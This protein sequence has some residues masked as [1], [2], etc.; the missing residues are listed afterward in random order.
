MSVCT[1]HVRTAV[2]RRERHLPEGITAEDVLGGSVLTLV[3]R[4]LPCTVRSAELVG[5]G[6]PLPQR[7][8]RNEWPSRQTLSLSASCVPCC[9]PQKT[10]FCRHPNVT[11]FTA[12]KSGRTSRGSCPELHSGFVVK[13]EQVELEVR[14]PGSERAA[15]S[16]CPLID[17]GAV[18]KP[19]SL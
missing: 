12:R 15:F 1:L 13:P 10:P 2:W 4:C 6:C 18:G 3:R 19:V 17:G 7:M 11:H 9:S 14:C 16:P 5:G 8:A